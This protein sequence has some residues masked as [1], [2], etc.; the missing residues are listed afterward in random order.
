METTFRTRS[1]RSPLDLISINSN[2]FE[3]ILS[4][5]QLLEDDF[6]KLVRD[7]L[8]AAE[9]IMRIQVKRVPTPPVNNTETEPVKPEPESV[10]SPTKSSPLQHTLDEPN[11]LVGANEQLRRE[12]SELTSEMRAFRQGS[13]FLDLYYKSLEQT[14]VYIDE[15]W[16]YISVLWRIV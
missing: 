15:V 12:K 3:Q 4:P 11:P 1:S 10:Q 8:P 6:K 13:K 16:D 2:I 9:E 7:A 14:L 5:I